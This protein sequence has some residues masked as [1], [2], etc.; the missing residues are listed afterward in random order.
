M[1]AVLAGV[2][3]E[4]NLFDETRDMAYASREMVNVDTTTREVI[5]HG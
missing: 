5:E 2:G 3:V 1:P 4:W